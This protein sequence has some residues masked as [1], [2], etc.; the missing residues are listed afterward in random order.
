[1]QSGKSMMQRWNPDA[2][3]FMSDASEY[4]SYPRDL[5]NELLPYLPRDG[6]ICDAGC[7]LGYLAQELSNYC[8]TVTA[9]D[10]AAAP[11][12]AFQKRFAKE[13]LFVFCGDIITIQTQFDAMVF[14]YF[15]KTE[16]ILAL[17]ER[18]CKG[19]VLVVKRDCSAHTFSLG[20]IDRKRHSVDS[21][22]SE[23]HTRRIPYETKPL[24][25]ELGQPFRSLNDAMVFYRLYN[26]SDKPV[27]ESDVRSRLM[28]TNDPMFPF[29]LPSVRHM[30]LIVF[31]AN[32]LRG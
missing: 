7:G 1:M 6:H 20:K 25:I 4:G 3:R 21:L 15:G 2:L 24:S 9:I 13:N 18:L 30:E 17:S 16:E 10:R 31:D 28:K 29:Y 22:V 23:L 5:A 11:I 19:N 12:E 26:K 8:K 32:T 27:E 14:C